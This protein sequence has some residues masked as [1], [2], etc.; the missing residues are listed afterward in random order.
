MIETI[1]A[2]MLFSGWI[3]YRYESTKKEIL[4]KSKQLDKDILLYNKKQVGLEEIKK[5]LQNI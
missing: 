5:N 4:Q 3:I 1:I 2:I